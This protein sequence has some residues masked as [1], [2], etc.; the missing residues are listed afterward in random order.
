VKQGLR[1]GRV[2]RSRYDSY[3]RMLESL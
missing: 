3:R 1:D 2:S